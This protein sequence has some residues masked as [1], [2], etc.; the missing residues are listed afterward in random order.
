MNAF[1]YWAYFISYSLVVGA[2]FF[3]VGPYGETAYL[4]G[5]IALMT[6]TD[7]H[8]HEEVI[9]KFYSMT[10]VIASAT[11]YTFIINSLQD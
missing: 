2:S 1:D 3:I 9:N 10:L 8:A 6:I 7:K 5:L 4:L 11:V